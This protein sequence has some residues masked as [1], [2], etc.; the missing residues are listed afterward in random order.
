MWQWIWKTETII[1]S[2]ISTAQTLMILILEDFQ[3][4]NNDF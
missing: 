3:T 4:S 1:G 2:C